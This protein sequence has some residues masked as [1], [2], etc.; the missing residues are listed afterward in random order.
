MGRGTI[1]IDMA[2]QPKR[3]AGCRL[4]WSRGGATVAWVETNC[5]DRRLSALIDERADKIGIDAPLG[6]STAFVTA[7]AEHA[8]GRPFGGA[9]LGPV[10]LRETDRYIASTTKCRP[11]SVSA[12]RVAYS[13][14]RM[15]KLLP[16]VERSGS[17][18]VVEVYPAAA[19]CRWQLPFR[20][21]TTA[22][23]RQGLACL[24]DDLIR[25]APWLRA[26][27]ELW[28]RMKAD[29]DCTDALVC[30]LVARAASRGLCDPIPKEHWET[31]GREGWIADG[32]LSQLP[33]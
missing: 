13:A 15:A 3:T 26:S 17:E 6:W 22:A 27:D 2:S 4:E 1:S 5:D 33:K 10:T 24:V 30:A 29:D 16:E 14:I 23:N 19:L 8:A 18:H 25:A 11:L 21:Y 31:A 20:L 9:P 28:R 7:V 12:D 32:S